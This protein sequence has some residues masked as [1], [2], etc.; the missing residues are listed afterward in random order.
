MFRLIFIISLSFAFGSIHAQEFT[1]SNLPI[2][3]ITTA[4]EIVDEP[5]INGNISIIYNG[6]GQSN[7]LNGDVPH[8]SHE[9]GIEIRGQSSQNFEKMGY[10]FEWRDAQGEDLD[11]SFLS[12]P[13][14]SDFVL[15]G[16]YSDKSLVRNAMAYIIGRSIMDY[17]PRVEMVEVVINDEYRG[18]YLLTEKIKRD[19]DRVDI[20][21]LKPDE[22]SGDDL[23][24][25]YI[26]KID[27][28]SSGDKSWRSKYDAFPGAAIRPPYVFHYPK[29]ADLVP[30]QE[31]YLIDLIGNFEDIMHGDDFENPAFGFPRILD[32][33]TFVDFVFVNEISRNVDGYRISTFL[34]KDK[35]SKGGK[36][37]AGPVWDFNLGFGNA[38]YCNGWM[39]T[40]WAYDFNDVCPEDGYSMPFWWQKMIKSQTFREKTRDRWEV[41][42]QGPLATDQIL[43]VYDSLGMM[44]LEAANRNFEKYKILGEYVW[45]NKQISATYTEELEWTRNWILNRLTWMD[46]QIGSFPAS[47]IDISN[48]DDFQIYPIPFDNTLIIDFVPLQSGSATFQLFN[49]LGQTVWTHSL[50]LIAGRHV[51]EELNINLAAGNYAYQLN[52]RGDIIRNG[53]LVKR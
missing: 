13:K 25:G 20:N 30:E 21:K 32:V 40:G 51:K 27:K 24:G 19:N 6:L 34:H 45:P 46:A 23:T 38:E 10:G 7:N 53:Q 31:N 49:T 44:L 3:K 5:K 52:Q 14:E 11:T 2:L 12:F 18:V 4:E 22:I 28:L 17:A 43:Q 9:V 36:I 8:I 35:D 41:L 47:I 16:P 50:E 37:K 29:A 48:V 15:H 42:R 33:Q 39:T 26:F 1:S